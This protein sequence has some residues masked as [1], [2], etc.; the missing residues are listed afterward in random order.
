MCSIRFPVLSSRLNNPD[1]GSVK[2]VLPLLGLS[3]VGGLLMLG[4]GQ[5]SR[6]MKLGVDPVLP[7]L[8]VP[9]GPCCRVAMVA[10]LKFQSTAIKEARA[11]SSC[12]P[13]DQPLKESMQAVLKLE[14]GVVN[15]AHLMLA[16]AL[17]AG[18]EFGL[19]L[20]WKLA[21][22]PRQ[23][24]DHKADVSS[25]FAESPGLLLQI[26]MGNRFE[27]DSKLCKF[28]PM[29]KDWNLSHTA[30]GFAV[31]FPLTSNQF[32][33]WC[34]TID[35]TLFLL[36]HAWYNLVKFEKHITILDR[37][38]LKILLEKMIRKNVTQ[39]SPVPNRRGALL[40]I[41]VNGNSW[42]ND[43]FNHGGHRM[44]NLEL[45]WSF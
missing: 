2:L 31:S 1:L 42:Q 6:S 37:S 34:A 45:T 18:C 7:L 19:A 17:G 8:V 10:A 35:S 4:V 41:Q 36:L 14:G 16:P 9:F 30:H 12:E 24:Q 43:K 40:V 11:G 3:M 27:G 22:M 5:A 25:I 33:I 38:V 28:F 15:R 29:Y 13:K 21:A 26:S 39:P 23:V 32:D 20:C 44:L